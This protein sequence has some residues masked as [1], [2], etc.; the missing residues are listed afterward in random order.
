MVWESDDERSLLWKWND[1]HSPLPGSTLSEA[2]SKITVGPGWTRAATALGRQDRGLS[3]LINGYSYSAT[4]PGVDTPEQKESQRRLMEEAVATTRRR[5]DTEFLPSLKRDLVYMRSL[6]I[7]SSDDAKLLQYLEE[8]FEIQREHWYIH[9]LVVFPVSVAAENMAT[10]YREAMGDVPDEEPYL[11]LQGLDNKT[12]EA[13]R[14]LRDLANEARRSGEVARVFAEE[15]SP[16][17][18]THRLSQSPQGAEFLAKLDEFLSVYGYRSTGFDLV[19]PSWK[20]DPS[21][22]IRNVK[23]YL[24]SPPRDVEVEA[25]AGAEE[26]EKLLNA[27]LNKLEGNE[28]KRTQF[29]DAYG[30]AQGLSP[31]KEDH[32]FYIDQGSSAS[33]RILL[34]EMGKRL[35]RRGALEGPDDVFHLTLDELTGAMKGAVPG[36]LATK[37]TA[38][39]ME[40]DHYSKIIPPP[41]LGTMPPEADSEKDS[42]FQRM[43]GPKA[44]PRPEEGTG[45]LRGVSGSRGMATG[46]AKVV[47]SPD[48]FEKIQPGDIL[49]CTS[50]SPTWTALFGSVA[51]LISDSGGVL[52]H[53][54]IVAR[55]Y[56]LPA[57]VGVKYGTSTISDGQ[58]IT[59]DGDAGVVYIG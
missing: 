19:Y 51:A 16:E 56:R 53:T 34:A 9:F 5:W 21:F 12:L 47:R 33:L 8:L 48:E 7:E 29:L 23:G 58:V 25:R 49:V 50:T 39:R 26:S 22:V 1:I 59:V 11:L 6:D 27:V 32:A 24:S 43:D 18:T 36:D 35:A 40:R 13:D 28:P 2:V 10:L 15:T 45:V 38:R 14:A 4:K 55:E 30:S 46:P 20:E 17:G 37:A 54:A 3:R 57:V 42:V 52:S 44:G 31:L 41:S